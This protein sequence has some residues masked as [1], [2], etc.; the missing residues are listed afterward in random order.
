MRSRTSDHKLPCPMIQAVDLMPSRFQGAGDFLVLVKC[1]LILASFA[2]LDLIAH[3]RLD[4]IN[5][6]GYGLV[7]QGFAR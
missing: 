6:D 3:I 5:D 1:Q 7:L 2:M 4:E